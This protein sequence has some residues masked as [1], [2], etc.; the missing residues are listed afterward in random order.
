M[1]HSLEFTPQPERQSS[2]SKA[3]KKGYLFPFVWIILNKLL[4][5][6]LNSK[7]G[8]IEDFIV[9]VLNKLFYPK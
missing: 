4:S 5:I 9:L 7:T 3:I 2:M 6:D 8:E 1:F